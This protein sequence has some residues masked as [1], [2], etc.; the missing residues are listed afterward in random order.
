[1]RK[2]L[3]MAVLAVLL[4][5]FGAQASAQ[6]AISDEEA[7]A[8][9]SERILEN[10]RYQL[11]Q[12][13]ESFIVMGEITG[14]DIDGLDEGSFTVNGRQSYNFLVT[15]DDATLYLLSADP[16]DVSLSTADIAAAMEEE[17]QAAA[18]QAEERHQELTAFAVGMP[19]RGNPD[20]PVTI[21]EFSDFQCT[22]CSRAFGTVEQI[23]EKYPDD[24]KFVYLHFP[25]DNHPWAM[26]AAIASV[27]AAEQNDDAFW[28]LHDNYFRN[29]TTLN[30]NNIVEMSRG[31]L[32][33]SDLDLDAWSI[34]AGDAES[35]A[36]QAASM[37]VQS[38]LAAG[39]TYGVSGTPGFFV[40]GHFLNGALPLGTFEVLIDEILEGGGR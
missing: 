28:T 31:F 11:P 6:F 15:T 39:S 2:T 18:R 34:C 37:A 40:N 23:L 10:L 26:P 29:Q 14:T 3:S 24:V 7:A 8:Q 25:L 19:A 4:M 17:S 1:M 35:E 32:S 33:A 30:A 21:F 20:A 38:A 36:H 16:I 12:L 5:G 9:R 22:Y 13:R 27:C